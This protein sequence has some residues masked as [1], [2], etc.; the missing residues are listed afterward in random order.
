MVFSYIRF[1]NIFMQKQGFL[2]WERSVKFEIF[3]NWERSVYKTERGHGGMVP[4]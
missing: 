4:P 3:L 1:P 2:N